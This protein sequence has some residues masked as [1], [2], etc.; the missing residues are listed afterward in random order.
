MRALLLLLTACDPFSEATDEPAVEAP[1]VDQCSE[2]YVV[3]GTL[4]T[5]LDEAVE[6]HQ[7]VFGAPEQ[8][9][10]PSSPSVGPDP[11]HVHLGWPGRDTSTSV[12]FVWSTDRGTLASLVEWGKEGEERTVTEGVSY[13]YGGADQH[14][15]RVHELKLCGRLEPGTTSP[16]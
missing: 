2:T 1:T 5:V 12:S 6:P 7:L 15:F 14:Q 13:T 4:G 16:F 10:G 3:P 9:G 8:I 11:K